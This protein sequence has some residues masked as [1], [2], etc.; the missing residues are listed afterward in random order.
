M[1][2]T[3]TKVISAEETISKMT[4]SLKNTAKFSIK[5]SKEPLRKNRE[6]ILKRKNFVIHKT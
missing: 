6:S 5:K 1:L 3:P 2:E 4:C